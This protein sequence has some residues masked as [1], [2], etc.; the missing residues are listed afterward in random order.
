MAIAISLV[1]PLAAVGLTA[2]AGAMGQAAGALLLFGTNVAAISTTGIVVMAIYRCPPPGGPGADRGADGRQP[3]QR[4]APAP[5][6]SA[7]RLQAEG[8]DPAEVIAEFIPKA[9]VDLADDDS[10]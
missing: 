1:P 9:T 2:E 5:A 4:G 7:E 10:G 6:A 8:V 3:A